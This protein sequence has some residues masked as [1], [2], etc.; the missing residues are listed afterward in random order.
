[1]NQENGRKLCESNV[2]ESSKN[3]FATKI[4]LVTN[5]LNFEYSMCCPWLLSQNH[6]TAERTSI[7]EEEEISYSIQMAGDSD[8]EMVSSDVNINQCRQLV[9]NYFDLVR[10]RLYILP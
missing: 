9:Q 5:V 8:V 7:T 10:T 4:I 6:V 2:I 3:F 1:M